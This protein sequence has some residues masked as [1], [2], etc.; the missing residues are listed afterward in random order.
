[1]SLQTA[2]LPQPQASSR[3]TARSCAVAPEEQAAPPVG[4]LYRSLWVSLLLT[5]NPALQFTAFDQA[6]RRLLAR[7][8]GGAGKSVELSA[9]DA[10]LLGAAS[11]A[12]ATMLT[13]P[14]IRGKV[15]LQTGRG[16]PGGG[17]GET[18]RAVV[19]QEGPPGLYRGLPAQLLK[20]VLVA[21]LQL[22]VKEK[23]FGTAYLL[24]CRVQ[25]ARLRGKQRRLKILKDKR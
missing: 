6:R 12:L 5:L 4:G 23:S 10:F 20:T 21:A 22:M 11:K 1:V 24:V 13:Y 17:V 8:S 9:L 25:E 14:A 15:L 7:R 2:S 16:A 3:V 19:L 18:L